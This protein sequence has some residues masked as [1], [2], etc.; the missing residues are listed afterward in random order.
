MIIRRIKM[1]YLDYAEYVDDSLPLTHPS[2]VLTPF[3]RNQ[4]TIGGARK[5]FFKGEYFEIN[6]FFYSRGICTM[7]DFKPGSIV[8]IRY[9]QKKPLLL[10]GVPLQTHILVKRGSEGY[11]EISLEELRKNNK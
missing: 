8:K 11:K 4:R 1:D 6:K 7:Y 2:I 9:H 3:S 5:A 10:L